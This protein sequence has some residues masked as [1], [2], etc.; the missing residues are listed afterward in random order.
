M[1][2][3]GTIQHQVKNSTLFLNLY[4]TIREGEKGPLTGVEWMGKRKIR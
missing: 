1:Q 3:S 4:M 2:E